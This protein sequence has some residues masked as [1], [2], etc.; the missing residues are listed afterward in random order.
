MFVKQ[1]RRTSL[2]ASSNRL[3]VNVMTNL[4]RQ[5]SLSDEGQTIC[6]RQPG[7]LSLHHTS[8][9]SKVSS[10]ILPP[11]NSFPTL[12]EEKEGRLE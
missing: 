9:F 12:A 5:T 8:G 6:P 7:L 4:A 10:E 11:F 3:T 1:N 2:D